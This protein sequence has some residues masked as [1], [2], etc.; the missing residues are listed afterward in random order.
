MK[1]I[2]LITLLFIL[3]ILSIRNHFTEPFNIPDVDYIKSYITKKEYNLLIIKIK[4]Y[5]FFCNLDMKIIIK[6][7]PSKSNLFYE[8]HANKILLNNMKQ[9]N[10]KAY[11]VNIIQ[12]DIKLAL[13]KYINTEK[14]QI[15]QYIRTLK[16][17]TATANNIFNFL[18]NNYKDYYYKIYPES[19]V[20]NKPKSTISSH[21]KLDDSS[22]KTPKDKAKYKLTHRDSNE[23][24][25]DMNI[26][27]IDPINKPPLLSIYNNDSSKSLTSYKNNNLIPQ[28]RSIKNTV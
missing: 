8:S 22:T 15:E 1:Y 9:R 27:N 26:L 18:K 14:K 28:L 20:K 12:K 10:V 3:F 6:K 19:K 25:K 21:S 4:K 7:Y 11:D 17:N 5:I 16:P 2:I 23:S 13:S 24:L